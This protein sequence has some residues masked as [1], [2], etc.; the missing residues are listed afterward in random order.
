MA[1]AAPPRPDLPPS[2]APGLP[3]PARPT[4][5]LLERP[6]V[7]GPARPVAVLPPPGPL[8]RWVDRLLAG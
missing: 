6:A 2:L 3:S 5:R 8:G 7:P 4:L 1:S